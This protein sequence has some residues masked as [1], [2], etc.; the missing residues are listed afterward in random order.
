MEPIPRKLYYKIGEV[1]DLCE[2]QPHVLRYWE[3]EFA[4]LSPAKNNSGQRVYRYGDLQIV[5]RIKQLL[6]DEGYTIAGANKKLAS[7]HFDRDAAEFPPLAVPA[8]DSPLLPDSPESAT[9]ALPLFSP[10]GRP[11][12]GGKGMSSDDRKLLEEI[13]SELESVFKMLQ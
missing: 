1:C 12:P 4:E 9:V 7:E 13:R 2:I 3:T 8:S 6:Y 11:V 10:D 5:R